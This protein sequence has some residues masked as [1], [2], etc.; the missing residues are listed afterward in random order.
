ML[1]RHLRQQG[2]M[3]AV[4]GLG[5]RLRQLRHAFALQLRQFLPESENPVDAGLRL[6]AV[7]AWR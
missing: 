7:Q 5:N 2:P 6:A 3:M 4:D 1:L